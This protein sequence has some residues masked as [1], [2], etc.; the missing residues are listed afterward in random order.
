L[1]VTP[2]ESVALSGKRAPRRQSDV[3][4]AALLTAPFVIAYL[5]LFIYPSLKMVELS[6]TNAPLIGS[7]NF[8]GLR[9]YV[10]LTRDHLFLGSIIHTAYFVLLTVIPNTLIGLGIAILVNRLRGRMRAT[11]LA[12]FFVPYVLP[13]TV[14]YEIWD[15]VLDRQFGIA[16]IVIKAV[17][18]HPI[19]VFANPVWAMPMVALVT[20]WWTS[21]FNILIFLAGLRNIPE[22]LYAA[23]A[24]D[25]AGRWRSFFSITWP[26]IW[27]ITALV[28]T[29]QLILQ[30]KIFDQVY[31]FTDGGPFNSTYVMV[32]FIYKQAF[33]LDHG[34]YASSAA[35][36]L[37]VVIAGLSLIQ[38]QVLRIRGSE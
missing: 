19:S 15:W 1:P 24:L 5:V 6:F 34:G 35:L 7:G 18:G 31:L 23:A 10:R 13:S 4:M 12:C 32:Q 11:V 26:L 3:R 25:G 9:N 16:Q 29:I 20:I 17:T 8:A 30:L 27:P 28:M 22:D 2:L 33:V 38:F 36:F 37:F 21:G 14:V